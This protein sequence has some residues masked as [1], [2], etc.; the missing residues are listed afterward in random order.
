MSARQIV[1]ARTPHSGAR[2]IIKPVR[3]ETDTNLRVLD[4]PAAVIRFGMN[5]AI[6]GA[7]AELGQVLEPP[8]M[9]SRTV[10]ATISG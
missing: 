6:E 3:I 1:T 5:R 4:G 2:A 8:A 9:T 7:E 10:G